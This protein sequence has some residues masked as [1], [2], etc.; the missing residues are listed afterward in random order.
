MGLLSLFSSKDDN[1]EFEKKS[2]HDLTVKDING[3]PFHFKNLKG[4]KI[5]VVNTASKCGL[6]P[7]YN[8][9]QEL[10]TVY[11]DSN[12]TIVGFPSNDFLGQ[13][14]GTNEDIKTF[15]ALNFNIGFPMMSKVKVKGKN[16]SEIYQFLTKKEENGVLSA[17]VAWNFQKFLIDE[18][19]FVV[20]S[21][22]PTTDPFHKKIINWI[23]NE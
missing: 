21:I 13:E 23:E 11:E 2:I 15:C 20:K 7:Q 16:K 8:K 9:L 17:K 4:K 10:Y 6:T 12:F 22:A 5:M 3:E 1:T 14:P 18:A 19:G